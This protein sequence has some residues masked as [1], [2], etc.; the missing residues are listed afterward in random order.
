[1]SDDKLY[2]LIIFK[3]MIV[4]PKNS[5]FEAITFGD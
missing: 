3:I 4:A 5:D 2:K 1:M